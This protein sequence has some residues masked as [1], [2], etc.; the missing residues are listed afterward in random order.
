MA[1]GLGDRPLHEDCARKT[2]RAIL[3]NLV[4]R[5]K[6]TA[7]QGLPGEGGGGMGA[8]DDFGK[9]LVRAAAGSAYDQ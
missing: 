3:P 6:V 9:G 2:K 8:H 5:L 4:E 1:G 7:D